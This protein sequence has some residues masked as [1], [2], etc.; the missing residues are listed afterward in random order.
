MCKKYLLILF[1]RFSRRSEILRCMTLDHLREKGFVMNQDGSF[2]KPLAGG[3]GESHSHKFLASRQ[4]GGDAAEPG[5]RMAPAS[6]IRQDKKPLMNELEQ[7]WFNVLQLRYPCVP[8]R[9]QAKRY[10]LCSGAW[11]KPDMTAIINGV[12]TAWECK[13]P[14]VVKGVAKGLLALKFAAHEWPEVDFW[15]VWKDQREWKEQKIISETSCNNP[16]GWLGNNLKKKKN[17]Q[18]VRSGIR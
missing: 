5:Q 12:E 1:L 11:Y 13:G 17:A 3:M 9:P 10:K 15:L 2:S 8:I 7:A 4:P 16:T 14:N 18:K 6:R